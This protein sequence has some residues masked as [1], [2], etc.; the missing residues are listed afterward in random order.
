MRLFTDS[1]FNSLN[2]PLISMALVSEDG[3]HEF[4]EVVEIN[5]VIDPWVEKNVMDRLEKEAINRSEFQRRLKKFL[6]QFPAVHVV[7]DYPIDIVH[8]CKALETGPGDWMEI[9][10]ITFEIIEALS[11]KAS[12]V[13]HNALHDARAIRDSWLSQEGVL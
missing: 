4:Y 12:K 11:A 7:A 6:Q 9:Q 13:P 10:P 2:G 8:V 5:E 1:E 3:I